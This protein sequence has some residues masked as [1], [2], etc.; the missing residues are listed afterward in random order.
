MQH[1]GVTEEPQPGLPKHS[2]ENYRNL[3][4]A[5]RTG[6]TASVHGPE[7]AVTLD[8]TDMGEGVLFARAGISPAQFK[9]LRRG[10]LGID[11]SM[12]LHG[13]RTR[14]AESA[15]ADFLHNCLEEGL[16]TLLLIHGKG[17]RSAIKGGILKPLTIQWLKQQPEVLAF[18]EAQ[19]HDGGSGA[20]Y[21]VLSAHGLDNP[22][23]D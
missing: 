2:R 15:L 13:M 8:Q 3:Q 21:V 17:H 1:W 14:E 6:S 9:Q 23:Y 20:L 22:S 19:P 5:S 16:Q 11:E 18:C 7:R 10:K 4:V 12:D